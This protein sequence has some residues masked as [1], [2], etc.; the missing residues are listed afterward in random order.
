MAYASGTEVTIDRSKSELKRIVY[1]YGASNYKYA[2]EEDRAMVMFSKEARIIRFVI[3]FPPPEDKQFTHTP[4]R[5][6]KRTQAAA[7]HEYEAEQRRRWRSLI[8]AIKAKFELVESGI[9]SF[10]EEFLPYILLPNKQTVA[11][12]VL[13]N[14]ADA[15]SKNKVQISLMPEVK[16]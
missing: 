7:Y 2:E 13:P 14:V 5:G 12:M 3:T 8:L 11:E 6:T 1:K 15:Y 10:E 9:A 16:K 4:G